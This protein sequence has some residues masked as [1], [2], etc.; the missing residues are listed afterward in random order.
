[1]FLSPLPR[2]FVVPVK[3]PQVATQREHLF[4]Q[5]PYHHASLKQEHCTCSGGQ[6][7]E[8]LPPLAG[9]FVPFPCGQD[10][11]TSQEWKRIQHAS[12][13]DFVEIA[14]E[15]RFHQRRVRERSRKILDNGCFQLDHRL[16]QVRQ[17]TTSSSLARFNC[18]FLI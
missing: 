4:K 12:Q 13:A 5:R 6:N 15:I 18:L 2:F 10:C 14:E 8:L 11:S 1:M 17:T 7:S 16:R 9:S 3:R